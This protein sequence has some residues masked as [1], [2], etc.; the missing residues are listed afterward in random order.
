MRRNAQADMGSRDVGAYHISVDA[1]LATLSL[2]SLLTSWNDESKRRYKRSLVVVVR[3]ELKRIGGVLVEVAM[4]TDADG[5][6]IEVMRRAWE[7]ENAVAPRDG[8]ASRDG[9]ARFEWNDDGVL[10]SDI[11]QTR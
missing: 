11:V 3:P 9:A 7:A 8:A 4:I 6:I 2:R 5:N 10:R 1:S